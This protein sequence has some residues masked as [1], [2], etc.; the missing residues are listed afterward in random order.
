MASRVTADSSATLPLCSASARVLSLLHNACHGPAVDGWRVDNA[1][2]RVISNR[3]D[4]LLMTP[5]LTGPLRAPPLARCG[6]RLSYTPVT[7]ATK[8]RSHHQPSSSTAVF[9]G[10]VTICQSRFIKHSIVFRSQ[11]KPAPMSHVHD[12]DVV[13]CHRMPRVSVARNEQNESAHDSENAAPNVNGR[14]VWTLRCNPITG[15]FGK[16]FA[17]ACNPGVSPRSSAYATRV[18]TA[19]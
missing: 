19:D 9:P 1:P 7:V 16:R 18:F 3:G 11:R 6:L 15:R 8:L 14:R 12:I 13:Y 4:S 10:R 17:D 2:F 5:I